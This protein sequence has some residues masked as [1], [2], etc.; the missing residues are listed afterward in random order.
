[1]DKRIPDT[2]RYKQEL[3]KLYGRREEQSGSV[4]AVQENVN[5]T[6][7]EA[8]DDSVYA[9]HIGGEKEDYNS[10]YPEPDLSGLDTDTGM[11]SSEDSEPP[12]Y[13]A[14][15]LLGSSKGYILVNT[16]TGDGSLAVAGASVTVTALVDGKRLILASGTT[17]ES[18]VSPR[19][20][21]PVPDIGYSQT[22][23]PGERPYNLFDVSVAAEGFF[24][25]RSVDVPVFSGI[26]SVQ[27]F[28]LIPVP[29]MMNSSDETVTYYNAEPYFG[30]GKE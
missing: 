25:A 17:D 8:A 19:F 18:G 20:A 16:R 27:N 23:A 10:R 26:T 22:P 9:P 21:V 4:P 30:G 29:L 5:I 14:E 28:S 13:D 1:M 15:D 24:S 6:E 12:E 7:E 11:I 2:E 3:M